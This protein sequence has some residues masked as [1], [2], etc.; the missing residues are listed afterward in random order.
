MKRAKGFSLV[1]LMVVVVVI[2]ILA[3]VAVPAYNDYVTRGKLVEATSALSDMRIKMEQS[4]QDNRNYT[5]YVV[6]GGGA[7]SCNLL[8]AGTTSAIVGAKYF[9][10][11]C[12]TAAATYTIT[13]TGIG[14][15]SAFIYTIDQSNTKQTAGLK[16]GWGAFPV[17]CWITQKGA[18]C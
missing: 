3:A 2:G 15:L 8:P 6:G 1:E 9:T 18:T 4:F 13:A 17:N 12:A 11:A 14:D 10:Y 7:N 16:A 5:S